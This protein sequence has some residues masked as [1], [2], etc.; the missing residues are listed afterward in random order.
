MNNYPVGDFLIRIK[1]AAMAGKKEF[2]VPS[3]KL[4]YEVAKVLKKSGILSKVEKR[5]NRLNL[6]LAYHKKEPVLVDLKLVSK[7]G[8]R[9]YKNVEELQAH[10][11]VSYFILT[12]PQGVMTSKDALKKGIG[13]E[14]IVEIW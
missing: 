9:I 8:L 10:K 1:N 11:G 13:G 3:T 5:A 7:P 12:T 2:S 4:V 6:R 14:V